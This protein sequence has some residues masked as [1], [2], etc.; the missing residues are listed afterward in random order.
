MHALAK[1]AGDRPP[2]A[3]EWFEEFEAAMEK[4]SA[5]GEGDS[6]YR[7]SVPRLPHKGAP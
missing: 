5:S 3:S 7:T 4:Q 2:S 1:E 6:F